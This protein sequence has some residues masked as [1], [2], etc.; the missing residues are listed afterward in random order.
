MKL[1]KLPTRGDLPDTA[2]REVIGRRHSSGFILKKKRYKLPAVRGRGA[3]EIV[4]R[5]GN[6][7]KW[8]VHRSIERYKF[9]DLAPTPP[10]TFFRRPADNLPRDGKPAGHRPAGDVR[11]QPPA[12]STGGNLSTAT[13]GRGPRP[14]PTTTSTGFQPVIQFTPP[15]STCPIAEAGWVA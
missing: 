14:L 2:V 13:G 3:Y 8:L 7:T 10:T 4:C 6:L 12:S 15:A 9:F 1:G 5:D 11:L